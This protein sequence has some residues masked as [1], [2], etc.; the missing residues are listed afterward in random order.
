MIPGYESKKVSGVEDGGGFQV[1]ES[2]LGE[3]WGGNPLDL[4]WVS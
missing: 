1:T 4:D 3:D 2:V